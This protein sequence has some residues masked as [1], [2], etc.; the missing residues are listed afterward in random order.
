[1][2]VSDYVVM[3][4]P[5]FLLNTPNLKKQEIYLQQKRLIVY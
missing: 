4:T 3:I 5:K 1:M 2:K